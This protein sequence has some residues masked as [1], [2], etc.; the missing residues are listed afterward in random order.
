[1]ASKNLAVRLSLEGGAKVK[2]ELKD[3]GDTGD[4]A[5]KRV[6]AASA[7]ASTGLRAL[8]VVTSELRSGIEGMGGAASPAIRALS[9]LGAAGSA[10]AVG[11]GAIVAAL[12]LA[13]RSASQTLDTFGKITDQADQLGLSF[14]R[15]QQLEYV[16]ASVGVASDQMT[17]SLT[18]F[19]DAI[20]Q[21]MAEGEDAPKATLAAFER[22]GVTIEEIENTGGDVYQVLRLVSDGLAGMGSRAE[23]TAAMVDL[24]G[25]KNAALI[26]V[27][28][29][30]GAALDAQAEAAGRAAG[31]LSNDLGRAI[32]AAGDR[33]A[34]LDL[35]IRNQTA[36]LTA[37]FIPAVVGAKEAYL[38][39]LQATEA[40]VNS[41]PRLDKWLTGHIPL[42]NAAAAAY[43]LLQ[44][45]MG[46]GLKPVPAD[47]GGLD[48]L[49]KSVDAQAAALDKAVARA[50]ARGAP[51]PV[52]RPSVPAGRGGKSDTERAAETAAK[53]AAADQKVID[54]LTRSIVTFGNE[55]QRQIDQA[56]GR[57]SAGAGDAQRKEVERLSGA[58]Y[59][60]AAAAKAA[61]EAQ[62]ESDRA[63]E[64]TARRAASYTESLMTDT[65]RLAAM[66]TE[67]N[68]LH[69]QGALD[70]ETY[71]R[72][73]SAVRA[74]QAAAAQDALYASRE[75]S[76][77]LQRGMA[78]WASDATDAA[79]LAE[80]SFKMAADGMADAMTE[81]VM[82]GKADFAGLATAVIAEINRMM[83]RM[84]IAMAMQRAMGLA[85]G[86]AGGTTTG[87]S[88]NSN[89]ISGGGGDA[90]VAHTGG[91][92]GQ[93]A[94]PRRHALLDAP[95]YHSGGMAGEVPAILQRGEGVFTPAQMR[96]LGRRQPVAITVN[97][98]SRAAVDVRQTENG[99]EIDIADLIDRT[100]AGLAATPGSRLNRALRR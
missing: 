67:L 86:G 89:F 80:D 76:D 45:A 36:T 48:V 34:Q 79:A 35:A 95:R 69:S 23:Q 47:P 54:D 62:R 98:N 50:A 14:E 44:A 60:Q 27:L 61:A 7:P 20:G 73:L 72:G 49:V 65:E 40:V 24:F 10:A 38:G 42:V 11:I 70:A 1:M 56:L 74:E 93:D 4:K 77:G 32:D 18:K 46:P 2:A 55:R 28:S 30:G 92:I 19:S 83:I 90:L 53:Q 85:I 97:N 6:A 13:V 68:R 66:Q 78:D 71:Q 15:F 5:L 96:A 37:D 88:G 59:D 43:R 22:L 16:F 99:A 84:A 94:L 25:T 82:T 39:V 33:S 63:A 91:I 58:L 81:F 41:V 3:V 8:N 100:T 87:G 52:S 64:E 26:P 51:V 17:R 31:V 9:G 57:L 21:V 29:Q 12:T 75:F